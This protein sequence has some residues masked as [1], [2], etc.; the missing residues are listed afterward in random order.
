MTKFLASVALLAVLLGGI[1][2]ADEPAAKPTDPSRGKSTAEASSDA[3]SDPAAILDTAIKAQGGEEKLAKV[4]GLYF[5][6]KGTSYDGD[7]K[8]PFA[9]EMYIAPDK[10][11]TVSLDEDGQVSD[12]EVVNG[13][14]GWDKDDEDEASGLSAQSIA[15][16]HDVIYENFATML[17][18]LKAKVYRLTSIPD[19]EVAGH[20][21][22]GILVRRDKHPD[23]KMYF[24]KDTHLLAKLQCKI[25]DAD[26]DTATEHDQEIIYSDYREVQGTKQPFKF[27]QLWDGT[28]VADCVILAQKLFEKQL[29]AKLFQKP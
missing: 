19:T 1:A 27:E 24:D 9:Y 20:T 16:E 2:R 18:P 29:D 3:S 25:K 12:I 13:K 5:K 4:V 28:K 11:R 22:V 10:I 8:A 7:A 23:L 21:A 17:V 14:Q 26:E 6:M 15:A